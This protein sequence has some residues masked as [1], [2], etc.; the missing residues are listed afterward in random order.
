MTTLINRSE[1][2]RDAG[3]RMLMRSAWCV[4]ER[5]EREDAYGMALI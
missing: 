1:A 4:M 2:R 5:W 3:D